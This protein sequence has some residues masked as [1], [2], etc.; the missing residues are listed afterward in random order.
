MLRRVPIN[1]NQQAQVR[2]AR[3][4]VSLAFAFLSMLQGGTLMPAEMA[5]GDNVALE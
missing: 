2:L 1:L 3:L 5:W 4:C